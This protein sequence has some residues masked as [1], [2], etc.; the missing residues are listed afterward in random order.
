MKR[1]LEM[2]SDVQ[3]KIRRFQVPLDPPVDVFNVVLTRGDGEWRE[4]FGSEKALKSFLRGVAADCGLTGRVFIQPEIPQERE[5][6]L[7]FSSG[8]DSEDDRPF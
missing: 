6:I 7:V 2:L 4:S 1:G 3:V 8:E 5:K